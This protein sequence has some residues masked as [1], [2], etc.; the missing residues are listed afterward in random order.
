MS[1]TP[2]SSIEQDY[3]GGAV[4]DTIYNFTKVTGANY[5]S[6][7]VEE[8]AQGALMQTT[9]DLNNG[10]HVLVGAQNGLTIASLGDDVMTGGGS[11][12]TFVFNPIFGADKITDFA[13]HDSGASH[14]TISLSTTDFANFSAV[15][16]DAT[17]SGTGGANTTIA[18]T[19]T[20]DA[21]T[22]VGVTP[23]ALAGLAADFAFH[24]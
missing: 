16:H 23:T 6:Y 1:S 22:F 3:S 9:Y 15:L 21:L 14:D 19:A 13:A 10:D 7:Q 20:G 11:S 5:Y 12:E 24:S 17:A 8:N 18:S 4:A 2:Y